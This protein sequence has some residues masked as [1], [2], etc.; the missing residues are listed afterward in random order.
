MSKFTKKDYKEYL[1]ATHGVSDY[2]QALGVMR[3]AYKRN[4]G[5]YIYAAD[6]EMFCV[7]MQEFVEK[8]LEFFQKYGIRL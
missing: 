1:N 3:S 5:D 7:C 4:Y 6:K 2:K 8:H